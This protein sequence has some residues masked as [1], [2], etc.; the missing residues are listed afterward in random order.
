MWLTI[1]I[2]YCFKIIHLNSQLLLLEENCPQCVCLYVSQPLKSL[3]FSML[4][5]TLS[6]HYLPE[7]L[8]IQTAQVYSALRVPI[9]THTHVTHCVHTPLAEVTLLLRL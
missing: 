2:G 9:H 7:Y 6:L 4:K 5:S 1:F 3:N 8:Q